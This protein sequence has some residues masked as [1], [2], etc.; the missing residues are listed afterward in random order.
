MSPIFSVIIPVFNKWDLT[1]AC[2]RSLRE[3]TPEYDYEVI[4]VD[5]ASS[6]ATATELHL[7]GQTLFGARFQRIRFAQ[8]RNFGPACNAGAAAASAPLLFFLNNDTLLTPGWAPPLLAALAEDPKLGGVGPLLLYADN[9]VQHLGIV[10]EVRGVEHIY[11]AFP[12][13]HPVVGKRRHLQAVTAAALLM[14]TDLFRKHG[15][16]YEEYRNGFEDVDLCLRIRATGKHFS[17]VPESVVY[18]LESQT[19]GR[20]DADADNGELL[21]RRCGHLFRP[22]KHVIG[23]DDGFLPFINDGFGISLRMTAEAEAALCREAEGFSIQHWY[24]LTRAHPLWV[25][26]REFLARTL[27]QQGR[28][29]DA[30]LFLS[31]IAHIEMRKIAYERLIQAATQADNAKVLAPAKKA[32]AALV[33]KNRDRSRARSFLHL[34]GSRCDSVLESLYAQ[35]LKE[36]PA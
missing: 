15:G 27:E 1:E 5:N 3:H 28:I 35:A 32:Y 22:D 16:F 4:V 24:S 23:R 21:F 14:P 30:L 2:L 12:S 25:A 8:N 18:H 9:T 20:S 6:D 19:A 10:F 13:G 26:G 17:C 31:E 36:N 34:A 11:R 29:D 33:A 7:L